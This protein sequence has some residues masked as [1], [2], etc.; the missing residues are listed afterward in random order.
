MANKFDLLV[1]GGGSGGLAAAKKASSYGASVALT[2]MDKI[3][4]TCVNLG[5]VPKKIMWYAGAI[6][7]SYQFGRDY[8]FHCKDVNFNFEK[9]VGYRNE[10]I[11]KL[12]Q[13]YE[14]QLQDHHIHYVKGQAIF[15]DSNTIKIN[16]ECYTADQYCDCY[17][18]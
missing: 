2:E 16:D 17:R 11:R 14:K 1:I 6:A 8:G 4:G 7:E 9:L 5:C 3:G 13:I 10:Y 12:N 15:L 18:L